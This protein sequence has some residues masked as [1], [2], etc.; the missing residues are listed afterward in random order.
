MRVKSGSE[1]RRFRRTGFLIRPHVLA[2][3]RS[4]LKRPGQM[5]MSAFRGILERYGRDIPSGVVGISRP[6][7]G[8]LPRRAELRKK[9][10][11]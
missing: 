7:F 3:R 6:V 10:T 4:R 1:M 9:D 8:P 2:K 5:G 11:G